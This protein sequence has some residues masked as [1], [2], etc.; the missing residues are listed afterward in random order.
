M[1]DSTSYRSTSLRNTRAPFRRVRCRDVA[2]GFPD[3]FSVRR[4]SVSRTRATSRAV[5]KAVLGVPVRILFFNIFM[6]FSFL[7]FREALPSQSQLGYRP[8]PAL[9]YGRESLAMDTLWVSR[10]LS[11]Y[12]RPLSAMPWGGGKLSN[13]YKFFFPCVCALRHLYHCAPLGARGQL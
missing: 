5:R 9:S 3:P 11:A 10:G 13:T 12:H 1:W 2:R 4:L 6:Q 7:A 8:N